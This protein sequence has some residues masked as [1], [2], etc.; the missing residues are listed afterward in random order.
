MHPFGNPPSSS[1]RAA[2]LRAAQALHIEFEG[3]NSPARLISKL[4]DERLTGAELAAQIEAHPVLCARVLKVANSPYYGQSGSVA[5]IHRALLLLGVNA[6]RGVAAAACISQIVP[7]RLTALPDVS[8][9]MMHSLATAVACELLARTVLPSLAPEAFIAGLLHNLGMI[10]QAVLDP[11]GSAALVAARAADPTQDLRS[12]ELQYCQPGHETCAAVLFEAWNLPQS[13]VMSALHHHD[14]AHAPAPHGMFA[15]L[16][17][18]G[19]HLAS[20]CQYTYCLEPLIPARDDSKLL[21]LG[22]T[23]KQIDV[24]IAE[25]Q[26][27]VELLSRALA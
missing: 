5:T 13:L 26:P 19:G 9:I 12:V 17:W 8:A 6:V 3:S 18:A 14:P 23:A 21:E 15:A 25:L 22:F 27:R 20:S 16:V 7:H 10:V 1:S 2:I 4:C 24:V 11:T